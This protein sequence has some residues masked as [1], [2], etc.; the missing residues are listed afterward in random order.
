MPV[1]AITS[2]AP[3]EERKAS[4]ADVMDRPRA[5]GSGHSRHGGPDAT[6]CRHTGGPRYGLDSAKARGVVEAR[7]SAEVPEL[8]PEVFQGHLQTPSDPD[9]LVVLVGHAIL[10]GVGR[11]E[12]GALELRLEI[13]TVAVDDD[14]DVAAATARSPQEVAVVTRKRLRQ[15]EAGAVE[16]DRARLTVVLAEDTEALPL[17]RRETVG[18]AGHGF[19]QLAPA[20]AIGEE[21]GQASHLVILVR[22][23]R[24]TEARSVGHVGVG[25]EERLGPWCEH[26]TH[27]SAGDEDNDAEPTRT[28]RRSDAA[29]D[30]AAGG[31][32]EREEGREVV[33]LASLREEQADDDEARPAE[34]AVRLP[35]RENEEEDE[36]GEHD[37]DGRRVHL[38][39][40]GA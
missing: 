10:A 15:P 7:G 28:R 26:E 20:D 11:G 14:D 25:G 35:R 37:G 9:L 17:F 32:E 2:F 1:T 16:I 18:D 4:S 5:L 23:R 27:T 29:G 24:E 12:L 13:L 34:G 40:P 22:L 38:Q 21:L 30:D 19:R 36:T 33:G 6:R 3:M 31:E 39:R 8:G